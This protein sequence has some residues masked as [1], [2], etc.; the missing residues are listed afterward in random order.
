MCGLV[1]VTLNWKIWY[2]SYTLCLDFYS[3]LC[4][5]D[6]GED[7][8]KKIWKGL[9]YCLWHSDKAHVQGDLINKLAGI[10]ESLDA[11]TSLAFFEV[12]LTTMR[13]EW[14]G[15][16][17]LRLDKFYRLLRQFLVRVFTLLQKSKWDEE[18]IGKYMGALVEK[19]LLAKDQHPAL[20]VN[21]H[22]AEIF[23]EELRKFQP[24]SAG[25][26]RLMLQP[27][28][29]TLASAS[30]KTLLKR[31]KENV[32]MPLLEEARTFV[33]NMQAGTEV[34]ENSFGPHVVSLPLGARIFELASLEAT[35]Q[36]NRKVLYEIHAEYTKLDKLVAAAGID[37]ST[38][39]IGGGS[40]NDIEMAEVRANG[41]TRQSAR[42]ARKR[43][44]MD[45]VD[46]VEA[47][48]SV[49]KKKKMKQILDVPTPNDNSMDSPIL[50]V[51]ES[52]VSDKTK[53]SSKNKAAKQV[54]LKKHELLPACDIE[55]TREETGAEKVDREKNGEQTEKVVTE[56]RKKGKKKALTET[57]QVP[58]AMSKSKSKKKGSKGVGEGKDSSV[59]A[60]THRS[61]A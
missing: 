23:L 7:E 32:F 36:A 8:L 17:R 50:N 20:G 31:V 46:V 12:F 43:A 24:L 53:K 45:A 10:M 56:K 55:K 19:S 40:N 57:A 37:L 60:G 61:Q 59:P 42:Q 33:N 27:C 11:E 13:R 54:K 47:G 38:I 21:L 34:D 22:F 25:T 29:A 15:I 14:N 16:D 28:Y 9:F 48:N 35:P 5:Q 52:S 41:P 26:L 58:A 6:V 51:V 49:P 1:K 18:T 2:V 44:T 3:P 39:K 30:D 4:V